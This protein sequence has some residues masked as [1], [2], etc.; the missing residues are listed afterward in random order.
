MRSAVMLIAFVM[1]LFVAFSVTAKASTHCLIETTQ[2]GVAP[3]IV[4]LAPTAGQIPQ[5]LHHGMAG[6]CKH[7]CAV[8]AVSLLALPDL[9]HEP[10]VTTHDIRPDRFMPSHPQEPTDRPPKASA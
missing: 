7:G 5:A 1:A 10:T 3:D 8:Q 9:N 6:S 4:K 2:H